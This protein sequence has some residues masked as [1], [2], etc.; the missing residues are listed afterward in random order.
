MIKEELD[1][2]LARWVQYVENLKSGLN[3][4]ERTNQFSASTWTW[5]HEKP[6]NPYCKKW[7]HIAGDPKECTD[8][9]L[10]KA[11]ICGAS[12]NNNCEVMR[13]HKFVTAD[14]AEAAVV[15][16]EPIIERIREINFKYL[17]EIFNVRVG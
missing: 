7:R 11:A 10:R 6:G 4:N 13:I 1:R 3:G 12:H 16:A 14:N 9:I 17:S 8:C 15:M 5:Y 2:G